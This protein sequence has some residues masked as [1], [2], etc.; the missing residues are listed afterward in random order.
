LAKKKKRE[1]QKK[2]KKKKYF[3]KKKKKIK[4]KIRSLR[5]K[6]AE[7]MRLFVG[8]NKKRAGKNKKKPPPP[9]FFLS[10]SKLKKPGVFYRVSKPFWVFFLKKNHKTR[11]SRKK[12][13]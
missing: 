12:K 11:L 13:T 6:A 8:L 10:S 7:K 4:K 5:F 9:G 1:K 3:L 2:K